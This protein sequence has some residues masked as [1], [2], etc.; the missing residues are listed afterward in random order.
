[1]LTRNTWLLKAD[2]ERRVISSSENIVSFPLCMLSELMGRVTVSLYIHIFRCPQGFARRI[3]VY[4]FKDDV[5]FVIYA[6]C[7][8]F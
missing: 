7:S 4:L 6:Y 8:G 1:M 5:N 2:G 3:P